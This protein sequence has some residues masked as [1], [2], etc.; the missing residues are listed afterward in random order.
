MTV[1]CPKLPVAYDQAK[2]R[3]NGPLSRHGHGGGG[4][5]NYC[6]V[7]MDFGSNR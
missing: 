2:E 6:L 5:L 7:G 1:L 4:N 3:S